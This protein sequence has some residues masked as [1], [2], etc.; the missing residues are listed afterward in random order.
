MLQQVYINQ[1]L[2]P[3]FKS[4]PEEGEMFVLKENESSGHG[5]SKL[6]NVQT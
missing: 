1:I 3:I 4:W 2:K 5:S 6:N